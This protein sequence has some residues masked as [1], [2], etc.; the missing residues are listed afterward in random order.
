[1]EPQPWALGAKPFL[2]WGV[3]QTARVWSNPASRVSAWQPF[4]ALL[5]RLIGGPVLGIPVA[6]L[7]AGSGE[8]AV[9]SAFSLFR[10]LLWFMVLAV[11][12]Q[13]LKP[14][15]Q[16]LPALGATGLNWA[17]DLLAF[18]GLWTDLRGFGGC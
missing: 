9:L 6:A 12:F 3:F 4:V 8:T 5:V 7:F 16:L 17:I 10:F 14:E 2:Y 11:L 1:M 15:R 18:G 13:G